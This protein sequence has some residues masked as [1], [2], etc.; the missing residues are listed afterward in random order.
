MKD[1]GACKFCASPGL[2]LSCRKDSIDVVRCRACGLIYSCASPSD[3]ELEHHYSEEYFEPYLKSSG[4]HE[5]RRFRKRIRE[6]KRLMPGGKLLDVGSGVGWFLKLAADEG[7][8]TMGVDVSPWACE[9]ART[10]F[11]LDVFTGDFKDAG[12]APGSLD[13]ITLWH[14]LEHVRDPQGFLRDI[15]RLLKDGGLLAMEIPNIASRM[16]RA[17]GVYWQLMAPREHLS[18]FTPQT[19]VRLLSDAGFRIIQTQTYFWTTPSMIFKAKA[20]AQSGA[21]RALNGIIAGLLSPF[22]WLRFKTLPPFIEGDVLTVY[23][24]KD[25]GKA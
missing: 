16:A 1:F 22:S 14:I 4:V 15:N 7:Y 8:S 19:A 18:Y 21:G 11:T 20:D 17:A 13:V 23:A 9:Y 6:I 25:G 3:T 24:V 10:H 12:I 5:R 2:E